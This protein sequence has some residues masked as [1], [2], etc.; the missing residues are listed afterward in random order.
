MRRTPRQDDGAD[1]RA[2]DG[3]ASLLSGFLPSAA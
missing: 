2:M 3:Y 1:K